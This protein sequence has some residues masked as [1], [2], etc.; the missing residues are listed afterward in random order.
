LVFHVGDRDANAD[1]RA[2][3]VGVAPARID[4]MFADD[5]PL[6]G[7]DF[8]FTVGKW[9]DVCHAIVGDDCGTHISGS[10][11]HGVAA[12]GRINV[13]VVKRPGAGNYAAGINERVD[14]P[15]FL[16]TDDLHAETDIGRDSFHKLEV[17]EFFRRGGETDAPATVPA[18]GLPGHLTQFWIECVA[19]VVDLGHVVVGDETGALP[20]CMP[21][22]AGGQFPLFD[23]NALLPTLLGQMV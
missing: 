9:I 15:D 18:G 6:L 12:T 8:P 2:N 1:P 4:H 14:P 13:P 20:G 10:D 22:R 19:E 21:G 3:P 5:I 17:V 23:E 7:D 11:G 16:R